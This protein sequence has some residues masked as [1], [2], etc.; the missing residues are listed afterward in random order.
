MLILNFLSSFALS[1]A[2]L[3]FLPRFRAK[4]EWFLWWSVLIFD[5]VVL[6]ALTTYIPAIFV[7]SFD[8]QWRVMTPLDASLF[9]YTG[10]LL[11]VFLVLPQILIVIQEIRNRR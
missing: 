9:F 10:L 1:W 8:I 11:W 7:N 5:I 3:S 2:L 4:Q 6:L